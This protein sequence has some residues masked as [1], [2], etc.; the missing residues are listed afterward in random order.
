LGIGI[1]NIANGAGHLRSNFE[2]GDLQGHTID[3]GLRGV[4]L[5]QGCAEHVAVEPGGGGLQV[6][7]NRQFTAAAVGSI[8]D[9]L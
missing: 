2:T 4:Y 9:L 3:A 5:C 1:G 6:V 7:L 8:V